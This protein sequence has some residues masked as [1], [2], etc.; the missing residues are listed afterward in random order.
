MDGL[1]P[2]APGGYCCGFSFD[3]PNGLP[4]SLHYEDDSIRERPLAKVKYHITVSLEGTNIRA[5]QVLMIREPPVKFKQA[6]VMEERTGIE[7]CCCCPM[8]QTSITTEFEK[9]VYCANETA[10]AIIKIDNSNCRTDAERINFAVEQR[11]TIKIGD[12]QH[13]M[14]RKLISHLENGPRAGKKMEVPMELELGKIY[15]ELPEDRVDDEPIT[16][17]D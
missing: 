3:L 16:P 6:E 2:V 10:R 1:G 8:G 15:L 13:V 9:N 14:K 12:F 7:S 11:L 17:E 4:A 5:K